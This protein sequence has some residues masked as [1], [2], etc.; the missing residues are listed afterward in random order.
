M[1]PK[2]VVLFDGMCEFCK[3]GVALWKRLDW[4]GRLAFQDCRDTA[5][6]PHC[7]EP[8]DRHRM[9]EEMHVVTP[10]R[11]HALRGYAAI[12]WMAWRVPLGWPV[13]PLM[14]LPGVPW[15]GNRAYRWIARRRYRLVPCSH[16]EC[17]IH[18][19][20]RKE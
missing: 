4:R 12:R 1:K 17:R 6:L 16:G 8:L 11:K 5:N 10:D 2:A 19:G 15:L 20:E 18:F 7:A 13:A 9:L 3:R 14:Y